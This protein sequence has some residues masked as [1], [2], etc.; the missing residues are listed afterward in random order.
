MALQARKYSCCNISK[1]GLTVDESRFFYALITFLNILAFVG[2]ITHAKKEGGSL[3]KMVMSLIRGVVMTFPKVLCWVL[4]GILWL[5]PEG[6]FRCL[7][8]SFKWK[9]RLGRRYALKAGLGLEQEA[10]LG[11]TELKDVYKR[12]QRKRI[13]RYQGGAGEASP[14]S[15]FLGIYDMLL[16]VTEQMHYSDIMNLSRVSKSMREAVLPANDIDRRVDVFKRYSCLADGKTY[17]YTCD[18]QICT[19]SPA[20]TMMH[21]KHHLFMPDISI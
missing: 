18:K 3:K 20:A 7:P 16:A 8:I 6:L 1:S 13:P 12:V 21:C 2:A 19:V 10:E 14:L 17:C 5:L 4:Y 15:D 9:I 11:V